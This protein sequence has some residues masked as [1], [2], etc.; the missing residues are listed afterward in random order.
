MK[1]NIVPIDNAFI[2]DFLQNVVI[3]GFQSPADDYKETPISL[4][5][6]II[7][8]KTATFFA[9]VEGYTLQSQGIFDGSHLVIDRSVTLRG[10]QLVVAV[11]NGSFVIKK[12]SSV[13]G[14]YY[15]MPDNIRVTEEI[16]FEVWGLITWVFTPS[17]CML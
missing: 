4:D 16:D 1:L 2:P 17:I 12:I 3:T 11:I 14:I 6:V 13:N 9:K 8:N 7:K 5:K 15:F 10:T